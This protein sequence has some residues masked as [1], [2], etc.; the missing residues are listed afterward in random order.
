[1]HILPTLRQ[2]QYLKLLAEHKSFMA[3]AEK[4]YVSQP[5]L[6]SGIAELEKIL[7]AR[8]VDRTRGQIIL[9]AI[10][11][12]TL[13]RAE[14]ILARAE[15]LVEATHGADKP[16][17]GRFRLGVIPTIA[18]FLLPKA[19][20]RLRTEFPDLRLFLREDQTARLIAALKTGALDAAVIA[21]PYDLTGLD[22][23]FVARD[24]IFAAMPHDHL[25]S[26]ET[27]ITPEALKNEE[28]ILLED[29]HC[30]RDHAMAA[31]S[32]TGASGANESL[33]AYAGGGFA[34]TSLNTLVQMVGSGLGLSLLPAMAVESGMVPADDVTIRPLKSDHAFRDIVVIWRSGSSRAPEARL[35]A[36]KLK[37]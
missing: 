11:E 32:W 16:L 7:G 8:L 18:P 29:G 21:L 35:L 4:A 14:D 34:A 15:D 9:T 5:A 25:L 30:L 20:V 17:T 27:S 23:V 1:M 2:L 3:A 10:G 26:R 6:S 36:E 33:S 28:L 31:C 37:T 24:E 19:L 12:E 22:H 13:K